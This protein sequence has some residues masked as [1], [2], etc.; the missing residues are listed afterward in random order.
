VIT[1]ISRRYEDI[2]DMSFHV[3]KFIGNLMHGIL[4]EQEVLKMAVS[5]G[6]TPGLLFKILAEMS[7][8]YEIQWDR[9]HIFWVDE[10]YVP[11]NNP[12]SNFL[13]VYAYLLSRIPIPGENIHPVDTGMESP[14][15]SARLYENKIRKYFNT[16]P[17]KM[18]GKPFYPSFDIL[19]M[20]MGEDGHIASLFP[21]D[22]TIETDKCW[23]K[24]VTPFNAVPPVRRI[25]L[26]LPVI[27]KGKN[28]LFLIDGRKKQIIVNKVFYSTDN[29][30]EKYPV[31]KV[32]PEGK[33]V[34]FFSG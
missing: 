22:S 15:K 1:G 14:E 4:K 9:I 33:L 3:A 6:R 25:T 20:E 10:R 2:N 5:G 24:A 13:L 28:V 34:W 16:E 21:E 8:S 29:D 18:N 26:T 17:Y 12:E 32:N 30:K 31:S 27:N 19:L 23:V 11:Y 7:A